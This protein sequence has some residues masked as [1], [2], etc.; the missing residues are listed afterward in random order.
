MG[1]ENSIHKDPVFFF[2]FREIRIHAL[3]AF[4]RIVDRQTGLEVLVEDG[5]VDSGDVT[6]AVLVA[7]FVH[8]SI[9]K[10]GY[11]V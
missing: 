5:S 6:R 1:K 8:A 9:E 7:V 3:S 11:E 10:W 2:F 4:G